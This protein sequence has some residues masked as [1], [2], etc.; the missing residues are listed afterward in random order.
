MNEKIQEF[1]ETHYEEAVKLLEALGR[2]PAPSYHED[3]R[4]AF[5]REWFLAQGAG[6]VQI[7][8]AKNV[9]CRVEGKQPDKFVVLMAHT[10][11]VFPDME[12]LPVRREGSRLYAPGIGDDTANLVNLMMAYRYL[13]ET[14]GQP[15][16]TLLFVANSCEEGLGN[17]NG[18][19]EIF[20][21]FG[22]S[23]KEFYSFD[24]YLSQCTSRAV[25]SHRYRVRIKVQGGH[26]YL[27]FGRKN[28]I[29]EMAGLIEELYSIE[30]PVEEKTTYNVGRIEGGSTVNSIAETAEMLYEFRSE[31]QECLKKMETLFLDKVSACRSGD[32]DIQVETLGLRPGSGWKEREPLE[33]WTAR[34]Q[35]I[36]RHWY[37]GEL[38]LAAYS[39]DANIPLSLGILANTIGTIEG[40]GAHTRDEWIET[41]SLK[42]GM[43]IT[44]ELVS[45]YL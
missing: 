17:L 44:A 45:A 30:P 22:E 37:Q 25:G 13:K 39:T 26:S 18:C 40:G 33:V 5:C 23:V 24:G 19:R 32:V 14:G 38:D 15:V 1:I 16:Y 42:K 8:Q 4:A 3:K 10:D 34:N 9:I 29:R 28:A 43:G 7:D 2:I 41:A 20:R 31:S 35:Q 6:D 12:E 11:I 21:V 36:I 27:D